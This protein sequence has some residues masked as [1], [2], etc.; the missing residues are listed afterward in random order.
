[1]RTK[2]DYRTASKAA[3]ESFCADNPKINIDFSKWCTVIYEINYA[4]RD[5]VLET[6]EKVKLPFG[7]GNVT[8]NKKKRRKVYTYGGGKTKINL[9][10]DWVKTRKA[11]NIIYNMNHHTE[12]YF[13]GWRWFADS[14]R[15]FKGKL[16]SFKAT[17]KSSRK[18]AEYIKKPGSNY[19]NVYREWVK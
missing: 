5:Y 11:G 1:M 17:R 9:A 15:V 13:F 18:I 8:I 19:Q 4:Y 16:W 6:G 12:G 7:F 10:V 14:A 3:Y 2:V